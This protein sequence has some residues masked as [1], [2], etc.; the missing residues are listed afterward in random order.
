MWK[1]ATFD[2][3]VGIGGSPS[4]FYRLYVVDDVG[5][6]G[7]SYTG[8]RIGVGI[9]PHSTYSIQSA[10]DINI[11]GNG[12]YR[13]GGSA[14]GNW[15][16]GTPSTDIYYNLGNV[17]IGTSTV[18]TPLHIYNATS[19]TIRLEASTTGTPA[20]QLNRGTTSDG[21]LDYIISNDGTFRIASSISGVATDRL[22]IFSGRVGIG[23]SSPAS[24]KIHIVNSSTTSS[25]DAG[26]NSV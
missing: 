4:A 15:L 21:N 1:N 24:S 25:P 18:S 17:G 2:L 6:S 11:S 26:G 10:G 5:I 16:A 12:R 8:G 3:K 9:D 20:I 23:T 19:P 22:V 14:L 13:I 7:N